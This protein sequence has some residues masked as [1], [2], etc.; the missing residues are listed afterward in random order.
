MS[1]LDAGT[2]TEP[3]TSRDI[4][5]LRMVVR[6]AALST[7]AVGFLVLLG[8]LF[9][10]PFLQSIV[11][12]FVAMVPNTALGFVLAGLSLWLQA[13]AGTPLSRLG[14]RAAAA[15]SGMLGLLT[16]AEYTWGRD[17]RLDELLFRDTAARTGVFPGRMAVTAAVSFVMIAG[18]LLVSQTRCPRWLGE[19]LAVLP[20]TL[21]MVSL[22]GYAY[23]VR[24]LFW[25][26]NYK[27]MAVHTAVAF[28][29]LSLGILYSGGGRGFSRLIVSQTAGGIVVRRVLPPAVV[30][31]LLLA[32]LNLVGER[33]G[34]YGSEF[35]AAL[36]AVTVAF[37]LAAVLVWI[38][39]TLMLTDEKR[40][41]VERTLEE[42][43]RR[44]GELVARAPIGIYRA[45]RQGR[46]LSVNAAFA[47]LLGYESTEEVLNLDLVADVY[48]DP[49]DRERFIRENEKRGGQSPFDARFKRRDGSP[50]WVRI[51]A[52]GVRGISGAVE[53]FEGFIYDLDERKRAEEALRQSEE[54]YRSLIDASRDGIAIMDSEGVLKYASPSA[55]SL[56]GYHPEEL[57]GR[58]AFA[59]VHPA[60]V[61]GLRARLSEMLVEAPS[62]VP[63]PISFR[64]RHR[65]GQWRFFE[66]VASNQV[67][68]T[69]LSGFVLGLRDVTE[70][71]EGEKSIRELLLAVEQTEDAIYMTDPDGTITY[72]NPGFERIYGYPREEVRGKTPRILK[73]GQHDPAFYKQFWKRLLSGGPVREQFVNRRRDGQLVVVEASV[74][75]VLDGQGKRIGFIAVQSDVT[76]SRRAE[77]E[78]RRSEERFRRLFDSNTIGIVVADLSGLVL[79]TNDAY[80]QMLGY[81]REELLSGQFRWD[82]LTPHEHRASDQVAVEQLQATGVAQPWEKELLRK[83]G[84]RVPVL[85][86]V[87]MLGESEGR[88]IAYIVD[89]SSRRQLEEQ[90]RQAQKMEAIGQLAGG[91]AH[92]FN[93]LLTVILG[94]AELA[95]AEIETGSRL[96]EPLEEIRKAGE[97]AAGLTR[98]LLA[99]SRRQ[100]LEPRVLDVNE[101]V[102]NLDKMLRRLIGEDIELATVL[103]PGAG[104]IRADAG[105]IEQ[106]I[107]NLAV[108]ARDAMPGG[109]K[110]TI[111]TRNVD[112]DEVYAREHIAVR[113]GP[114]VMLAITDSGVGMSA[115]TK[116]HMF[117]PFFTTKEKGKGTGLGLATV[118]GIVKQSEGNIW[119]YSELHRGT[120]F[121]A[122]FPRVES[123][124][125]NAARHLADG[126]STRGSETVLLVEDEKAV[127]TLTRKILERSGY[128]VLEMADGEEALEAARLQPEP[129]HLLLTDVVM[130]QVSG[131]DLAARIVAMRPE[132]K[133]LFM[134]G[135][136]DD[137]VVRHG[138]LA[139]GVHFLQ[140]P[141]TPEALTRKIRE[142]LD[143][144][145]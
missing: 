115:E 25:I 132:V 104:R 17:L 62:R 111:E 43:E 98:Q 40:R 118:Y 101:L 137:A 31:P 126:R 96:S 85:I 123:A 30:A 3:S 37:V 73:S 44:Y 66:V 7:M 125:E 29:A 110:L 41:S 88:C 15:V 119:V 102:A 78:M 97:R 60:D 48:F 71:M 74:S 33:A 82:T 140:K 76:E 38:G 14:S 116:T 53:H 50:F 36:E 127:R 56:T 89:L 61:P 5:G 84:S 93:N 51:Q 90:F 6:A 57:L 68:D 117:E 34:R 75:P 95:A 9:G 81:T 131:P 42:S 52:R 4:L 144:R 45:T 72:V 13:D 10:I 100:V 122:Y 87:A 24:S 143:Q 1:H 139:D 105:Q 134:S 46:F 106:V 67:G 49:S 109:G 63:V 83:D 12:G 20:G 65:D 121:K 32:W 142:I 28:L 113:P 70:R 108:N 120:T 124:S 54:R 59:L 79:E 130:P 99:F 55:E 128:S 39:V 114:Y 86:G 141:F 69:A 133:V 27:G 64:L 94:F 58:N 22:T 103:D 112:L 129:I 11:P 35:G 136:T 2:A 138:V 80:L 135:Y 16:L 92:D 26:G 107:V 47:R 19:A 23:G 8:W 21:A 91:V 18:A 77:K 145:E